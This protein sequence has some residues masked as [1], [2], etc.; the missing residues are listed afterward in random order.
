MTSK[1]AAIIL[2]GG[3]GT[4]L[5]PVLPHLPKALAPIC[6]VPFLHILLRQLE[7]AGLFSKVILALG[8]KAVDIQSYLE[9]NPVGLPIDYSIETTPLGTGGALLQALSKADTDLVLAM[10]GDTF[11]DLCFS[12]FIAYH[13]GKKSDL[14]LTA[15]HVP[16]AGR[17]GCLELDPTGKILSFQEKSLT[18]QSGWINGGI[19]LF[20]RDLFKNRPLGPY[21][22]EKDLLPSLKNLY[23]FP[24]EATFID[25]GTLQSYDE[26]QEILKPWIAS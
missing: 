17:Y 1:I 11:F 24:Q 13:R 5:A 14:T 15:R 21:S 16:D 18:S 7:R 3:F 12:D 6:G 10:N 9:K 22:L 2:A 4:R 26:A 20:Q 25:I 23:A 19:Y 8:H